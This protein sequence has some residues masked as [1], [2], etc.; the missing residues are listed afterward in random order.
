LSVYALTSRTSLEDCQ[1]TYS[2]LGWFCYSRLTTHSFIKSF[3]KRF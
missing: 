1:T 3:Y 2:L